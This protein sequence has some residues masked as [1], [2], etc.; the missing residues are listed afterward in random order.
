[1]ERNKNPSKPN[2]NSFINLGWQENPQP[3]PAAVSSNQIQNFQSRLDQIL[4]N[5]AKRKLLTKKEIKTSVKVNKPP[6]GSNNF[7]FG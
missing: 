6:G 4:Q 2:N 7:S 5:E 1:M 3:A